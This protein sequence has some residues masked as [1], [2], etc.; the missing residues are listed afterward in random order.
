MMLLSPLPPPIRSKRETEWHVFV[1]RNIRKRV[2]TRAWLDFAMNI[3]FWP[4]LFVSKQ[5]REGGCVRLHPRLRRF[6]A[7]TPTRGDHGAAWQQCPLQRPR[8]SPLEHPAGAAQ[9]PQAGKPA[10]EEGPG[11][12]RNKKGQALLVLYRL[13]SVVVL[14]EASFSESMVP[15]GRCRCTSFRRVSA[16][17]MGSSS[18]K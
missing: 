3:C 12:M 6:S 2:A 1:V 8:A 10:L 5:E 7:R 4:T 11:G 16:Y 17:S 14:T 9:R 13:S 15:P 18:I